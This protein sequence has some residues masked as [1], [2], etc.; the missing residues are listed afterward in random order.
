[1]CGVTP[2]NAASFSLEC[3][4]KSKFARLKRATAGRIVTLTGFSTADGGTFHVTADR[5]PRKHFW[6]RAGAFIIDWVIVTATVLV[7]TPLLQTVSPIKLI[8]PDL[9][10]FGS[11]SGGLESIKRLDADRLL[12]LGPGEKRLGRFCEVSQFGVMKHY[13]QTIGTAKQEGTVTHTRILSVIVDAD[14]NPIRVLSLGLLMVI[15]AP[16]VFAAFLSHS[17]QTPGK[18]AMKLYV[19]QR[20]SISVPFKAAVLRETLRFFPLIIYAVWVIYGELTFDIE[21]AAQLLDRTESIF[22]AVLT[23]IALSAVILGYWFLPFFRWRG[24]TLYD[25]LSGLYVHGFLPAE[26]AK[27]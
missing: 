12:P 10:S 23:G 22:P 2:P 24:Q 18:A 1:M 19:A 20:R 9:L 26:Q 13:V 3:F 21:R 8:P 4:G 15:V 14:G 6:R 17:G 11:C 27:S 16:L 5:I 25:R 7:L